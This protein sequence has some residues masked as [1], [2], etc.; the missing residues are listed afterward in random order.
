MGILV[1][2]RPYKTWL[3]RW[4]HKLF[5][6]PTFW[7]SFF[8]ERSRYNCPRCNKVLRCYWDGNDVTGHGIDYCN[9]CTKI[10]EIKPIELIKEFEDYIIFLEK[11]L[12][13]H[14]A[15]MSNRAWTPD[16]KAIQ[17]GK[18]RRKRIKNLKSKWI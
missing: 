16:K 8:R 4:K 9:S 15:F 11:H 12:G 18:D 6:C 2:M 1:E 13:N 5:G 3:K 10:L 14:E 7:Y 17:E